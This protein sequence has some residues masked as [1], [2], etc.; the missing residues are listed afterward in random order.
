M[1]KLQT[2]EAQQKGKTLAREL[3]KISTNKYEN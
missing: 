1:Y 2:K 3:N